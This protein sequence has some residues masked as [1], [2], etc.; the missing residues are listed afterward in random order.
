LGKKVEGEEVK[1]NG[2]TGEENFV[3][4]YD[5][6]NADSFEKSKLRE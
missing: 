5:P 2:E 4:I 6:T 1:T 3:Y